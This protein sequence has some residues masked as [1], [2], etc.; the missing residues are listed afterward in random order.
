VVIV[1]EAPRLSGFG[2]EIAAVIAE[3]CLFHLDAPIKRIG[4][5]FSPIP[6]GNSEDLLFPTA[7]VVADA[8]R[9]LVNG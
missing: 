8:V 4:S 2:A 9:T 7:D 6:I 5:A 1:H 3:E